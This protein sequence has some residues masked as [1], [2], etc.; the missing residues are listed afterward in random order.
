M[1]YVRYGHVI[2]A[3]NALIISRAGPH[4]SAAIFIV[5]SRRR[6][7]GQAMWKRISSLPPS[8]RLSLALI[9][10]YSV[11]CCSDAHFPALTLSRRLARKPFLARRFLSWRLKTIPPKK[12]TNFLV[13]VRKRP[14][15]PRKKLCEKAL[16]VWILRYIL[17]RYTGNQPIHTKYTFAWESFTF[18]PATFRQTVAYHWTYTRRCICDF[19]YECRREERRKNSDCIVA[20]IRE[21]LKF[22]V[23]VK[24]ARLEIW[25]YSCFRSCGSFYGNITFYLKR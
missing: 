11:V 3:R 15:M 21:I 19:A 12:V 6:H 13:A 7:L 10:I 17:H 8:S 2:S 24:Y 18:K 16:L 25:S 22:E 20:Y 23:G 14:G 9:G 1:R 4:P 5:H